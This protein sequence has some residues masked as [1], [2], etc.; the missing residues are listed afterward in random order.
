MSEQTTRTP[1]QI[2]RDI[3]QTREELAETA[4]ALAERA[5]VKARAHE[6]LDETR[7]RITGKVDEARAKVTGGAGAA[8]DK[9]AAATPGTVQDGARSAGQ[10]LSAFVQEH[11]EMAVVMGVA[12][13]TL[14]G[15]L[16][17]RRR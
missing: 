10:R 13:G 12:G 8:K 3:E 7:A 11:P 16:V 17:A 15:W 9:A 5:D 4:A 14:L 6:K 2:R 1:E